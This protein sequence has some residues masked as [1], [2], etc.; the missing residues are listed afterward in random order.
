MPAAAPKTMNDI[1]AAIAG[2]AAK[3]PAFKKE[4]FANPKATIEKY[5]GQKMP[6]DVKVVA[7]SSNPKEIHLVIPELSPN[8]NAGKARTK[9]ELSDS[10]LEKV[11]G[12]E[13]VILTIVIGLTAAG[14]AAGIS[15]ANEQTQRRH[16]W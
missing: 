2:R 8:T 7:H 11:A 10:D 5:S 9:D 14:A 4:F 13:F 1:Q 15:I 16:G 6:A 3:D 12:G